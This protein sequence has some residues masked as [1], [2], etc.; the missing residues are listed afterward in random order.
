MASYCLIRELFHIEQ[1]IRSCEDFLLTILAQSSKFSVTQ[2]FS[3][4]NIKKSS[5]LVHFCPE[6]TQSGV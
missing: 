4:K 3:L 2:K 1:A 5:N 6:Q